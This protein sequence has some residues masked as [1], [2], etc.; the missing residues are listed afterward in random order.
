M[1]QEAEDIGF[2]G[3]DIL[4]YVKEQQ[5]LDREERAAWRETQKMQAQ[6]D[7]ELAK[8]RAKAEAEEKKRAD[9]L[10]AEEKKRADELQAEEKRRADEIRFAQIEAEK[11]LKIK[12][13]ELQAQQAQA[14]AS[15]NLAA[16]PPPRNKDSKS[17]KLPSFIDEKDELD[18]YLLRIER[19]AE[20]ASWEKDTWA[21]KLSALLT[22]TAMDVY[23]RMSD[24]D[25]SDYDK[26]K[27]ALLTRYNYTEDGYRKWFREATPETEETPDQF[28][29]RLKNY[30]AKWLELS[31]SS[32]DNFDALVDLIVKEQFINACSEDLAMYLLERG[33]KDL[34]ELTTWAQ[35]YLIAHKEQ[36]GKSKATVQPRRV[37]QKKTTQS[38][39]DSSQGRQRSLQCYRCRGFGHR[40]SEC[41][42]KVI[43]GK[44]QKG[45]STPVSQSSQKK[46]R[47]MV[48]QLDEDGEKA[49]TCVEVEGTRSRS[50]SK[51][52]GTEGST[53]SDRA[54]YSAVCRAQSNDGQTYV[55]VGKL[56]GRPVKVLRD[57]GCTGMI[58]DRA[59]VPE[60]LVIPGSS[61]SLQMVDHTLIDVPLANVYLD[62]PYYK[63]HKGHCR[64]MCVSSPVYPVI[65]GNVRG[66]RRMLPDPDW[67]A[68][69]QPGVRARTSGGN[70][71]KDN[72]DNQGGD[73]PAWMFRRSNQK[74]EKSA[75]KERDSKKKSAQPKENDDRVRRNVKVMEGATEEKCVAGPVVTRAQAKKS[76]KVH[77]LKVKEAMSSVDKST[78]E[79]LQKKD[80][81]L[82]KCFDRIWKPIIRENYVGEFYKKNG[83]L[84]RNHQE[85]KT[86]RSF[87]QLVVPKELRRQVMSVNHESAFSGHL[88]A[89]KTEVRILPNFFWPGLRQDIIRFCRSCDVCQR[90]VKRGSVKKV[91]LGSMP[92]IDT[93]FKRVAVDIAGPIA[94][95]SE[96][97]H[98]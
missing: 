87:N 17:L 84:Y 43:P 71:D 96:A 66:A 60:V 81:T 61:G 26:L 49:F 56:N 40:Q 4:E 13:M 67:K 86:G 23:T 24:A 2:E 22:G 14:Q 54:V 75:P 27:K 55:G 25:A 50:N 79:N 6:A 64:V 80:S 1:K 89:K 77:P 92:L 51:K 33:P 42:T 7:V 36:L 70:K 72:D 73:I 59:L 31:G 29:I 58:V 94:P 85:T 46:T 53:N 35:K 97:G 32:P 5:K 3:K 11:E 39:P 91:P 68:E 9:E 34:V 76:D 93:P 65:I 8:I 69:D 63:G 16:T 57:T 74:T 18:S 47:A 48:A 10:Q 45:S 28:V 88:G 52:S 62:S 21:I 78:I 41:G 95:P 90:T 44:D 37:D 98:R 82:K 20:N 12:E 19:Y 38:K 15:A 83:L 30:L